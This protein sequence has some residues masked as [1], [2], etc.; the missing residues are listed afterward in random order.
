MADEKTK[1]SKADASRVSQQAH[2]IQYLAKKHELPP[3]L[4]RNVVKQE[5][6]MRANVEKYLKTMKQNGK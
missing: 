1:R 6:P 2:E 4:V 5:G 3:P